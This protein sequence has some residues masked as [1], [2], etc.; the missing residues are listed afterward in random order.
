MCLA[1]PHA[2]GTAHDH[3]DHS[4]G[5]AAHATGSIAE[6]LRRIAE[7]P[8]PAEA[9]RAQ[10]EYLA[11]QPEVLDK[12][13][14]SYVPG[15]IG[16]GNT[17]PGDKVLIAVDSLMDLTITKAIAT[18]L[19]AK[20]AIVDMIV[21]DGGPDRRI[22]EDDEIGAN[23][24]REAWVG[25]ELEY[26]YRRYLEIPWVT[27]LVEDAGYDLHIQGRA[28]PSFTDFR[29]EGHPWQQMD[30]FLSAANNFPRELH[31][32]INQKAWEPVWNRGQGAHVRITDVEGTDF[33]YTLLPEY[34]EPGLLNWFEERPSI[35]HLM[36]HPGPPVSQ[37]QD[38][39]GVIKGTIAHFSRPFPQITA[40]MVNGRIESVEGGGAYGDG[41]RALLEETRDLQYPQFPDK[42]LFWLW[43][44]AIG[45]NPKIQ[46]SPSIERVS[47]G[48]AEWERWRSGIMHLGFGT[49]GPSAA[50]NWAGEQGYPY[51]HLHIHMM[52]PTVE[53]THPD[54]TVEV[55]VRDGHL[56]ALD[57]PE[58]RACAAKYGDPDI[59]L[60]ED[61]VP[62]IPGVNADGDYQ[63]YAADPSRWFSELEHDPA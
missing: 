29:W 30:H 59:L 62:K 28:Y 4:H 13:I 15:F 52:M 39:S 27:K 37:F 49:A 51:G 3:G 55:P 61:W 24:R 21:V 54:G 7:A 20:G 44:V 36:Y 26:P 53:I 25:R 48:G 56:V 16:F 1:H 2:D 33:W 22:E 63:V 5:H 41:W 9:A 45:T 47:S 17:K 46:R 10:A 11:E 19:R 60:R 18:A 42:G 57:D 12:T 34:W 31:E 35:G 23:I 8:T 14:K 50:E 43:E 38:A 58:V 32:M 40:T 6:T